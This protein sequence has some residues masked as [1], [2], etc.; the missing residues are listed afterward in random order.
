MVCCGLLPADDGSDDGSS[1]SVA[2]GI[3]VIAK[4]WLWWPPP[5]VRG[6]CSR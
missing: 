4:G 5:R 1:V 6:Y 2:A 3:A